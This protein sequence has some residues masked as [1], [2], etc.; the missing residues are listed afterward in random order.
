MP[1]QELA[2]WFSF[3]NALKF[4]HNYSK[5]NNIPL[6]EDEIKQRAIINYISSVS[7]DIVHSLETKGGIPFK[8]SLNAA[9]E[10][11]LDIQD[12]LIAD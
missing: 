5:E 4:T 2:N 3:C 8:Y 11:A 6:D 1:P 10:D 7:G 12:I 9:H